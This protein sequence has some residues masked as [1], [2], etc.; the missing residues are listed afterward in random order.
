MNIIIDPIFDNS[1]VSRAMLSGMLVIVCAST[2]G[3]WVVIRGMS[4][5]ADALTHGILPGVAIALIV[6]GNVILGAAIAAAVMIS[7]IRSVRRFSPLPN[8]VSISLLFVGMLALT[9]VITGGD[10]TN[11]EKLETLLFGDILNVTNGDLWFQAITAAIILSCSII[12]YRTF[13]TTTFDATLSKLLKLRPEV[14]E[15]AL[16]IL[17]ALSV[18]SSF[19][20]VG[21]FLLLALLVAPPATGAIIY[22]KIWMVMIAAMVQGL[23]SIY[24]GILIGFHSGTSSSG[25][26]GLVSVSIF[27]IVLILKAIAEKFSSVKQTKNKYTKQN[28]ISQ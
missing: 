28:K 26:A 16:L 14:A 2:I 6:N 10:E 3:S 15:F 12:F 13:L 18:I 21:S 17:L 1:E 19:K 7:G 20:A 9:L 8:D 27:F 23:I 5:F 11:V 4:Y 25:S 22:K 24:V